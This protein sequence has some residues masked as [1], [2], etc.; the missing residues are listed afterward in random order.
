MRQEPLFAYLSEVLAQAKALMSP[1]ASDKISGGSQPVPRDQFLLSVLPAHSANLLP[2]KETRVLYDHSSPVVDMFP[3]RFDVV[4]PPGAPE[5]AADFTALSLIP[6]V[7][8]ERLLAAM[9]GKC[10]ERWGA[11]PRRSG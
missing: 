7:D 9:L 11:A 10:V 2:A 1:K 5:N 4:M 3:R 8:D 6:F